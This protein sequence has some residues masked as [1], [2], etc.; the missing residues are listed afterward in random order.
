MALL[1]HETTKRKKK[2]NM[3]KWLFCLFIKCPF[4]IFKHV[5]KKTNDIGGL[6]G[7]EVAPEGTGVYATDLLSQV[8]V[9]V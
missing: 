6:A 7:N 5:T 1:L 4:Q 3:Y 2:P 9:V 8:R